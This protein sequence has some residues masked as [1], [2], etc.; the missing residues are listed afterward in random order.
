MRNGS[1]SFKGQNPSYNVRGSIY[2]NSYA[3]KN[4]LITIVLSKYFK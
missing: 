3:I 2:V 4:K 1:D